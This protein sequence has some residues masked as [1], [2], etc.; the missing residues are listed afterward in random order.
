MRLELCFSLSR[1]SII[2]FMKPKCIWTKSKK[3]KRQAQEKG[4]Q[5][6]L[7]MVKDLTLEECLSASPPG[8]AYEQSFTN[9]G[10]HEY[11][12]LKQLF[13]RVYPAISGEDEDYSFYRNSTERLLKVEEIDRREMCVSSLSR[14]QSVK[15]KKSVSFRLPEEAD[16][17]RFWLQKNLLYLSGFL[18]F[19][20]DFSISVNFLT[21]FGQGQLL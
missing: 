4:E 12:V 10:G 7:K 9:G 11:L 3:K 8:C 1:S 19:Y 18:I 6:Q 14:S 5:Q 15:V 17:I 20:Q 2:E 13:D 16:I 21:K